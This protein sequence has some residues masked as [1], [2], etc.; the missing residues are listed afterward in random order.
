MAQSP[1]MTGQASSQQQM[2]GQALSQQIWQFHEE[3]RE[4]IQK[5]DK[6]KAEQ[7]RKQLISLQ[8][9]QIV[10]R[11]QLN[12]ALRD[13][14]ASGDKQKAQ[15][16]REQLKE[17]LTGQ[18]MPNLG[19]PGGRPGMNTNPQITALYQELRDAINSKD[20]QKADQ[21]RKQLLLLQKQQLAR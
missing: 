9:Q 13:A 19:Q 18:L 6:A 2:T 5:G 12:D 16:L 14:F 10:Q 11:K 21:L 3:L 17:Q 15:Q 20:T 7:L 8:R 1:Q 4:A